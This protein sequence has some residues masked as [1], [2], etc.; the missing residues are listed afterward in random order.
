MK[1]EY[2]LLTP[3]EVES[4]L[5]KAD[6]WEVQDGFLLRT[7]KFRS[8]SKGVDFA[9]RVAHAAEEL[10]H[11]PVIVIDYR[12]VTVKTQTHSVNGLSPYDFALAYQVE[13]LA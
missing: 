3:K 9:L 12:A 13:G 11:H 5:Q 6:G 1:L 2:R 8:Y 10:D 4:S 7:F